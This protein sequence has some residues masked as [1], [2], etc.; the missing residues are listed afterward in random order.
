[1][2]IPG[3][4]GFFK[5]VRRVFFNENVLN[6]DGKMDHVAGNYALNGKIERFIDSMKIDVLIEWRD[7]V[8]NFNKEYFKKN[9][10]LYKN[11]IGD[12]RTACYVRLSKNLKEKN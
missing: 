4:S 5:A 12:G 1:L 8:A 11:D 9:W 2:R 7:A 6:L 10:K 3:E